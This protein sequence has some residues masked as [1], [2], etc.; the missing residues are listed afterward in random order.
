MRFAPS[1]PIGGPARLDAEKPPRSVTGRDVRAS[2]PGDQPTRV[3]LTGPTSS[4]HRSP[5]LARC[6]LQGGQLLLSTDRDQY[7]ARVDRGVHR[8]VGQESPVAP[9][10]CQNE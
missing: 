5:Y 10:Q 3:V 6:I 2:T 9:A 1:T 8:R 7:V 4:R